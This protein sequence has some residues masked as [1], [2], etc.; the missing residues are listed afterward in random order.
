MA[1]PQALHPKSSYSFPGVVHRLS[2]G[3]NRGALAQPM[4]NAGEAIRGFGANRGCLRREPDSARLAIAVSSAR[5]YGRRSGEM[6]DAQDLKSTFAHFRPSHAVACHTHEIIDFIS[7]VRLL[8]FLPRVSSICGFD[9]QTSRESS[10]DGSPSEFAY[11]VLGFGL[12]LF[13]AVKAIRSFSTLFL[14]VVS[15]SA[16][17]ESVT[18]PDLKGA[19]I[20]VDRF[21][22][23]EKTALFADVI[24][25]KRDALKF[26]I[27]GNDFDYSGH[28]SIVLKKPRKHKNPLFGLGSP[29]TAKLVI[30]ENFFK[31]QPDAT[32]ILQNATIWEKSD[33]LII[34]V[35]ADKEWIHSGNYTIQN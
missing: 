15:L 7:F 18:P 3:A 10:T 29:A 6:A 21:L 2:R 4:N 23:F 17:A 16:T 11:C 12:V 26:R 8:P 19:L 5:G 22:G 9:H 31:D 33:G 28:F 13:L 32:M 30:L 27:N 14:L 24:S 20:Y 35:A 34:A 1:T 25:I